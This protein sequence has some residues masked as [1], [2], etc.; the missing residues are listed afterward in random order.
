MAANLPVDDTGE[1]Y[2]PALGE[3]EF[4]LCA[5]TGVRME[6]ESGSGFPADGGCYYGSGI[7]YLT[8]FRL[9]HV[10]SDQTRVYKV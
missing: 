4:V 1:V 6:L 7:L 5:H 10:N 9:V 3:G 2:A 8:N